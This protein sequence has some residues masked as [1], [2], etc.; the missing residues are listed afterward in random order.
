MRTWPADE[1]IDDGFVADMHQPLRFARETRS[2]VAGSMSPARRS[3][4]LLDV[5]R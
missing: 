5:R 2:A 4:P 3:A 1:K